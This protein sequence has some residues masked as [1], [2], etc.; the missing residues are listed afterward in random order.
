MLP[1][2]KKAKK[3][4]FQILINIEFPEKYVVFFTIP[5]NGSNVLIVP[6]REKFCPGKILSPSLKMGVKI[7]SPRGLEGWKG[8]LA[9]SAEEFF[10]LYF[11]VDDWMKLNC[12]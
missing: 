3:N 6:G 7:L 1:P 4:P 10:A 8:N 2:Q 9:R 12:L 5:P 11:L